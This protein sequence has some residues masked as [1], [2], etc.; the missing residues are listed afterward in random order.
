LTKSKLRFHLLVKTE[1]GSVHTGVN[2]YIHTFI[3]MGLPVLTLDSTI[4]SVE[5]LLK[6]LGEPM[7]AYGHPPI[8]KSKLPLYMG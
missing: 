5:V 2:I 1:N 8:T 7:N 3:M 4:N 6:L